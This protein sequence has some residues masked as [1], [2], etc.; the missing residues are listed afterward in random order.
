[1]GVVGD[2]DA[3]RLSNS[4]QPRRD[5]DAVAKDIIF[6][7]DDVADVNADAEFDPKFLR[8]TGVPLGHAALDLDGTAG[9]VHGACELGQHAV[10]G[11]LDDVSAMFG[12]GGIDERFPEGLELRQRAFFVAAHQTAIAGDIR[13]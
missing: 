3:A 13:R 9:S 6:I 1:M 4:F 8:H 7:D 11:G 10:S 12:D 5:V 2:A